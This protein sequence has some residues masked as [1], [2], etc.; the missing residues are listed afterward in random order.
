M[1][2]RHDTGWLILRYVI[3][4]TNWTVRER[5]GQLLLHLARERCFQVAPRRHKLI[6]AILVNACDPM[7]WSRFLF[8]SARNTHWDYFW[9]IRH[10]IGQSRSSHTRSQTQEWHLI[11]SIFKI[12][13]P[14]QIVLLYLISY[15]VCVCTCQQYCHF[16]SHCQNFSLGHRLLNNH[17]DVVILCCDIVMKFSLEITSC[18]HHEWTEDSGT[19]SS[20]SCFFLT[21]TDAV[22]WWQSCTKNRYKRTGCSLFSTHRLNSSF[23]KLISKTPH[24]TTLLFL[25]LNVALSAEMSDTSWQ[26]A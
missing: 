14:L 7:A 16:Y 21:R 24:T 13:H 1:K 18:Y 5:K 11:R 4:R 12:K 25:V 17:T 3:F 22:S 19:S 10:K 26:A 6:A 9:W 8:G 2:V 20:S 23:L 15:N